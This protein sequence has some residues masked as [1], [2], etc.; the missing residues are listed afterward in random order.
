MVD[1]L[2]SGSP[3]NDAIVF[4]LNGESKTIDRFSNEVLFSLEEGQ[5]YRLKFE[6]KS[7]QFIPHYVEI[8]L[9]ILFLPI[10]GTL[11]VLTFNTVQEWEKDIS[12]FKISGYIDINLSE[13]TQISFD[14]TRGKFDKNV[15]R[16]YEPTISFFPDTPA[17]RL[18]TPD[19]E[20]IIKKHH[21]HLLNIVSTSVILF[22]LMFYLLCIGFKNKI[23]TACV[24]VSLFIIAFGTLT[25]YLILFSFKK[26]KNLITT[27]TSK[28]SANND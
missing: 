13:N 16:F 21:D 23:Y 20:E 17:E 24:I 6:Q 25:V 15:N 8:F 10:R 18:C 28:Q 1:L 2:I 22:A 11:N 3:D 4:S 5:P 26:R 19:V 12:A 7:E 27:L 9:N 14:L